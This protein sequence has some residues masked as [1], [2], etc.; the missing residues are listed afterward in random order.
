[1]SENTPVKLVRVY[2]RSPQRT[3]MHS[4]QGVEYRAV[5]SAMTEV[6]EPVAQ[7]WFKMFPDQI[8]DGGAAAKE[9]GGAAAALVAAQ[10]ELRVLKARIAELEAPKKTGKTSS[11]AI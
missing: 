8:I 3:L 11:V 1:M 10:E 7:V 9:L 2:N 4:Y 5:P 6:P